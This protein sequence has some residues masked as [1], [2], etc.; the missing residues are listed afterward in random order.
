M[1]DEVNP[2]TEEHVCRI[3]LD[4]ATDELP[5]VRPCLCD[6][7]SAYVHSEC[8]EAWLEQQN[9]GYDQKERCDT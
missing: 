1:Q 3:C 4:V 2:S 9:T 8:L 5:L 6:G 7:T